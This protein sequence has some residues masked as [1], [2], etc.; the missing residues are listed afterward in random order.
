MKFRE[1]TKGLL[2]ADLIQVY[3]ECQELQATGVLGTGKVREL[4]RLYKEI[5]H[6]NEINLSIIEKEIYFEMARRYFDVISN[7]E[8]QI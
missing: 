1:Y 6:L 7:K 5:Y 3:K 2:D 8:E 4:A